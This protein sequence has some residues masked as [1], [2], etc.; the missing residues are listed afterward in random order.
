[1]ELMGGAI[2]VESEPGMGSRFCFYLPLPPGETGAPSDPASACAPAQAQDG[3]APHTRILLA[4]DNEINQEIAMEL[5]R[6]LGFSATDLAANGREAVDA[7]LSKHYDLILMDIQMPEIDGFEATRRIRTSGKAGCDSI[8]II[9]MTA[10]AMETDKENCL[11]A[12]MNDHISKPIDPALL[13]ETL[14]RWLHAKA[15]DSDKA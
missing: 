11:R 13:S 7:A 15:E 3:T 9:A 2:W 8:P 12:G 1:V 4:E 5:L 6:L 10:N 14:R